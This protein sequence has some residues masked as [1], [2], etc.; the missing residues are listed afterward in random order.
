ML[1]W[2][3]PE[4]LLGE[5]WSGAGSIEQQPE[6][7]E[8]FVVHP[9]QRYSP[10]MVA[11][12]W[13]DTHFHPHTPQFELV[14]VSTA[15]PAQHR[16]CPSLESH[17]KPSAFVAGEPHLPAEQVGASW[18]LSGADPH[19]VPFA[20]FAG[21]AH[22]PPV[23]TGASWQASGA[24]PHFVPSAAFAGAAQVPAL[25]AGATWHTSRAIP[26]EVPSSSGAPFAHVPSL[27]AGAL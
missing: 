20:A 10:S 14:V 11:Q 13:P 26:H 23:H 9:V 15:S 7:Q 8:P 16:A 21:V 3:A 24:L 25:H 12:V 18:H 22:V 19:A 6:G 1:L 5:Q 2:Q 27:H 17:W 4:Q